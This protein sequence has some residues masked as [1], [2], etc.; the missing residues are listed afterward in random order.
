MSAIRTPYFTFEEEELHILMSTI[1]GFMLAFDSPFIIMTAP[2]RHFCSQ[3]AKYLVIIFYSLFDLPDDIIAEIPV[4]NRL[5]SMFRSMWVDFRNGRLYDETIQ[6]RVLG[7]ELVGILLFLSLVV[8]VVKLYFG[9]WPVYNEDYMYPPSHPIFK[10][11]KVVRSIPF[12][13]ASYFATAG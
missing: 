7:K 4:I 13:E 12:K 5:R 11:V 10:S 9:Y 1:L 3:M 8:F 6:T 2:F